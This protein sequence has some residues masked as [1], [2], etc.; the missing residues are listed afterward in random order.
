MGLVF[1]E[2]TISVWEDAKVQWMDGSDGCATM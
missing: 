2:D 1:N